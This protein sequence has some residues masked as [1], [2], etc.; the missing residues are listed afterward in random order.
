MRIFVPP[1]SGQ[2]LRLDPRALTPGNWPGSSAFTQQCGWQLN[3][4]A[5]RQ[6][7]G[8]S[9]DTSCQVNH[10]HSTGLTGRQARRDDAGMGRDGGA[11]VTAGEAPCHRQP[12]WGSRPMSMTALGS[13]R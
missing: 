4:F 1:S 5:C 9:Q 7:A 6:N 10:R 13:R 2:A 8:K 3:V 11:R 12:G